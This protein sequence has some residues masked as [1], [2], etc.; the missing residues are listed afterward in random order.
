VTE[1][2]AAR[3][4]QFLA[5]LSAFLDRAQEGIQEWATREFSASVGDP[6]VTA[7]V[8]GAGGLA[9]ID[10]SILA[11]RSLDSVTL[12]EVIVEAVTRAEA[13]AAEAKVEFLSGLQVGGI[14]VGN[15]L[16]RGDE[17]LRDWTRER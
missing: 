16:A 3:A 15:L 4:N 12:G 13:A 1:E 5:G 8:T 14:D 9:G 17:T 2:L 7:R 11:K 6:E 10:I